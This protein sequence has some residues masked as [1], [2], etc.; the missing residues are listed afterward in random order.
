V[1]DQIELTGQE[2]GAY[3][4]AL[5][6]AYAA[7]P[8]RFDQMM[9][10]H[11][12]KHRTIYSL[13]T[14][15]RQRFFQVVTSANME[16]WTS[17]LIAASLDGNPGNPRLRAFVRKLG[18]TPV[19]AAEAQNLQKV[20]TEKSVFHDGVVF[21]DEFARRIDWIC[22]I[23]IPGGGGTGALVAA[24][25]VLTN[26]H[27]I[28]PLLDNAALAPRVRCTF[29]FKKL[30]D[31]RQI[32]SG[33]QVV[34]HADWHVASRPHSPEDTKRNGA[35]PAA[36]ALDYAVLRLA[37]PVGDQA[38]GPKGADDPLSTRRAWLPVL[39]APPAVA[40]PDPV[41]VLQHPLMPGRLTQE[42]V[43]LAIGSVLESPYPDRRMRHNAR[44]L[45][46]SSGSPCFSAN[47][48]LV[49]LHH[50]GDPITGWERPA[51]NQAIPIERIVTDL[52]AKNIQ[53]FWN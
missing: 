35:E 41:F 16:G 4:S 13:D 15:L 36:D 47:L 53:Q 43:Q 2:L 33:R 5:E 10:I 40:P 12:N 46:G 17:D 18:L 39:S 7:N 20:V 52:A 51:W 42:P 37:E 31:G 9:L 27:V 3:I 32:S 45:P 8:G 44:T 50:A 24:D 38:L 6:N 48:E 19:P 26:H 29:D 49:G 1:P 14:D 28:R 21:L 23:Q 22:Q 34:L 11:L 25:L 30:S